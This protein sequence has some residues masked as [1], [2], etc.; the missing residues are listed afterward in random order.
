MFVTW[1][2]ELELGNDLIDTQHRMLVLLCRK[3]DIA[4]KS[5]ESEHTI[6]AVI[7]ELKKFAEFHFL[8]EENLMREIE[9]PDVDQHAMI[10]TGLLR[11][12]DSMLIK[13][14]RHTELPD[15]LLFMLTEWVVNHVL[16]EDQKITEHLK[17]SSKR[18][19]GEHLYEEY[20]LS[21]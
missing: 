7:L 4:I 19:I 10:H 18:P 3:L 5:H 21:E 11:Q 6:R 12:M 2:S 9:Y 14:N 16:H 1:K 8:S 17:A 20:L 13:I 15:D